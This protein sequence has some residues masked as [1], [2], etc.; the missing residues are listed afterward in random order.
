MPLEELVLAETAVT[1]LTPLR[2]MPLR[3]FVFHPGRITKGLDVLLDLRTLETI[4]ILPANATGKAKAR[5]ITP[6]QLRA[7]I[8]SGE[9]GWEK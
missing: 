7:S 5:Q 1:D 2:G 9:W 8:R 3:L 4:H 6:N